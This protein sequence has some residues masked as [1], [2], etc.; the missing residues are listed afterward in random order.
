MSAPYYQEVGSEDLEIVE[1]EGGRIRVYSGSYKD[2]KGYEPKHNPLDYFAIDVNE[3][4]EMTLETREGYTTHLFTLIGDVIIN[5]EKVDEKTDVLLSQGSVTLQAPE[6][7]E[8]VWMASPPLNEPV[9]WGGPIVMNTQ[10]ELQQA[11]FELQTGG[12][13]KDHIHE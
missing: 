9:A 8:V 4:G 7:A 2:A 10:E 13:L 11:F 3:G 5:G 6:G 12:F 1:E